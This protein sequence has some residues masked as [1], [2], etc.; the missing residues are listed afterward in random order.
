MS[1]D[2][3]L[4]R[5]VAV[6]LGD[7]RRYVGELCSC[8]YHLYLESPQV[9]LRQPVLCQLHRNKQNKVRPLLA[10]CFSLTADRSLPIIAS[11]DV[12]R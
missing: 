12:C 4:R 5:L 3:A 7:A 11:P 9:T 1:G 10:P 2:T 8:P 6:R